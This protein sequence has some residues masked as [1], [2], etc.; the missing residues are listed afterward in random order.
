MT[1]QHGYHADSTYTCGFYRELAPAWLDLAALLKGQLSPRRHGA[2]PF[3]YLE[4]GSGMGL[5]LCL[6]A[7]SHP[8]GQ[9]T[10]IDF[11]PDH[12]L[13]SRRLADTLGLSNIRFE[14][15]DF[16]SL[17]ADPGGL[18]GAHHYV[19]AH[20]IA[21]WITPAIRQ[22]LLQLASDAL[23]PGGLF[24]CSYNTTPGWLAAVPLQQL[25][26][27]ESRRRAATPAGASAAVS[28]AAATLTALLGSEEQPSA[29]ARTLPGLRERLA[30]L[31]K[32]DGAY[33]VQEYI[34]EGW[35]PLPVHAMHADAA[36][37]KLRYVAS[38]TFPENFSGLL[39]API[40][41]VIN[42]EADPAVRETLQDLG[43]NQSFRR[44]LFCHGRDPLTASELAEAFAG[45][46]LR[47]L[48]APAQETYTFA[49]SF[50]QI[51]GGSELYAAVEAS[52]ADGVVTFAALQERH[53]LSLGALAQLLSLLLHS[54]RIGLDRGEAGVAAADGCRRVSHTLLALQRGGRPYTFLPAPAI[55]SAVAI[56]LPEALL[57]HALSSQPE[58]DPLPAVAAGLDRL[59][60]RLTADPDATL[61]AWRRRQPLLV[62]LG[63]F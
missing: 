43:I 32:Q 62:G 33:L 61:A 35:Q 2:E 14:E 47:L 39:P 58:A 13:H 7:A 20:G 42:A 63:V 50:G 53:N 12:I 25:A 38:A 44:D 27:L 15:A 22:A 23:R 24:Y 9:F 5:G 34:N 19:V 28:A 18:R 16:L 21:T 29:L 30:G 1:W 46:R 49:T 40:R 6:L 60:R 31:S 48:D 52:I 51:S 10:G 59:G 56:S 17:A 36:G 11:Q 26:W 54:G 3:A 37:C 41:T 55:G 8:E 45:L 4:L 57:Q